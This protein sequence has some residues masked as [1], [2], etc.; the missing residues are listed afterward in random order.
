MRAAVPESA[1]QVLI[2][3]SDFVT[4]QVII[5][6]K[7]PKLT[8]HTPKKTKNKTPKPEQTKP[9]KPG[10][11]SQVC[12]GSPTETDLSNAPSFWLS[13][14]VIGTCWEFAGA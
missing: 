13:P 3:H 4:A 10:S 6:K 5:F 9:N 7:T 8:T 12:L 14:V 11:V 1:A 2:K